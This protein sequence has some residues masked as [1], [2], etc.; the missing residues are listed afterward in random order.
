MPYRMENIENTK[1]RLIVKSDGPSLL[2][3]VK[4]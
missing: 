1:G 3:A 4:C 2:K